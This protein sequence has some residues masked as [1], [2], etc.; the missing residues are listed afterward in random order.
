MTRIM[1]TTSMIAAACII[2]SGCA[3]NGLASIPLPAPQIGSGGFMLTALF[4]NAL[5]LPDKAKVKLGGADIG[6]VES[7][8]TRNYV[9]VTTLRIMDGVRLPV[10]STAQLRSATPLGDVFVSLAAPNHPDP[11]GPVLKDGDTIALNSTS[12]A[13]TVESVLSSAALLVNGGAVRNLTDVLNGLGQASGDQ[14]QAFGHLIKESNQLLDSLDSRSGQL[15]TA[16]D[17]TA[18]LADRLDA[19]RATINDLL[20][21]ARPAMQTLSANTRGITD[22]ALQVGD[23]S[24]QLSKFPSIAGT[25]QGSRSFVKDLN[26]LSRAFNDAALSP[27]TSLAAINRLFPMVVKITSGQAF[28]VNTQVDQ[29]VLGSFP[30][31]GFQGDIGLHGPKRYDWAKL[32][33]SLKYSLWRLQERVVGRGPQSPAD[34]APPILDSLPPSPAPAVDQ[35]PGR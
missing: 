13:S 31:I 24:R 20:E 16:L 9:A 15:Q 10:G 34:Q 25:D 33:G 8:T 28:S 32:I 5:N 26:A 12:A 14:G 30:D 2:T 11:G 29:L 19:K 17:T 22:L 6:Q 21:A 23:A 27:D 1:K 3:S 35:G 4:S 18:G 7:M